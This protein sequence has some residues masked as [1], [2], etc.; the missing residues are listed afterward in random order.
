MPATRG[1]GWNSRPRCR[2]ARTWKSPSNVC[3]ARCSP[4]VRSGS[5]NSPARRL[6]PNARRAGLAVGWPGPTGPVDRRSQSGSDEVGQLPEQG[7]LRL[8]ADDLLHDLAV[9]EDAQ[10]RNVE[11]PVPLGDDRVLVDVEL[12]YVDLLCMLGGDLLEHRGDLAA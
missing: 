7:R 3:L 2:G 11:D 4:S 1:C 12:D 6:S 10:G 8:G 9:L 5:P